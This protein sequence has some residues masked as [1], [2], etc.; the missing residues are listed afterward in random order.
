MKLDYNKKVAI[1]GFASSSRGQAPF[2]DPTVEI[3]AMNSLY[4]LIPRW[5]RLFELHPLE[6]CKK[7]HNR[8]ELKQLGLD[9]FE[10]L[11]TQPGPNDPKFCPIYMQRH[12]EE[13]PASVEWPREE[14]NTWTREMFG[15]TAPVDY[16]GSTPAQMLIHALYEGYGD[17]SLY[18]VDLL[19]DQEYGY[20]RPNMEY[21]CG[22]A[23][24]LNAK[25]YV[26]RESAILKCNYVYGYVEPPV[27][28]DALAPLVK[29]WGDKT[30][31]IQKAIGDTQRLL[32][33]VD[34][35]EQ[36][37]S[38]IKK[39][40]IEGRS[41]EEI[42]AWIGAEDASLVKRRELARDWL[43]RLDAQRDITASGASWTAHFGRGGVLE[44]M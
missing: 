20:Q 40:I 17:I 33:T 38:A 30:E 9:H 41:T 43:T 3:W 36:M 5:D 27:T 31:Q 42:A 6:H 22:I 4:A 7:D 16:F 37:S 25:L 19:Q 8:G 15:E 10:F 23:Y 12:Y 11:R 39:L 1:V 32:S 34:G 21:W 29:F 44:G 28:G 18:G 24:G 26:P 2:G 35:A 13:I 14:I